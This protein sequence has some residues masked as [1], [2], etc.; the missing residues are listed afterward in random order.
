MKLNIR[1]KYGEGG[2]TKPPF[3]RSNARQLSL[4]RN[5]TSQVY[6]IIAFISIMVVDKGSVWNNEGTRE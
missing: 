2:R 5:N 4:G 1:A 3:I 6:I